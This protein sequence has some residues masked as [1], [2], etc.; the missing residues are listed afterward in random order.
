MTYDL[1]RI[2][3]WFSYRASA[4]NSARGREANAWLP[5]LK[6]SNQQANPKP[7]C[8]S[9]AQQLMFEDPKAVNEAFFAQYGDGKS[10][11]RAER[12]NKRNEIAKTL[13]KTTWSEQAPGLEKRAKETHERELRE[14][15]L[16]LDHVEEAE[17]VLEYVSVGSSS[18]DYP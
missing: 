3:T 11:T 7:R 18:V 2:T 14:W 1:Q 10:L 12:M 16:E 15:N 8:R 6:R 9:A 17:E 5:L 4:R 13:V